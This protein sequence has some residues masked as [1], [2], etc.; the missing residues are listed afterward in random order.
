MTYVEAVVE[1]GQCP[2][3]NKL[4]PTKVIE[5]HYYFCDECDDKIDEENSHIIDV[6]LFTSSK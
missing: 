1:T 4:R 3:C 5:P 2:T 6:R